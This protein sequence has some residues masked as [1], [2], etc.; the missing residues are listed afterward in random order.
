MMWKAI[1]FFLLG[2]LLTKTNADLCMYL[3]QNVVFIWSI[4]FL[5]VFIFFFKY[6]N[7]RKIIQISSLIF[8]L[9]WGS[10]H[11]AP[12]AKEPI[13]SAMVLKSG[14]GF[15]N[16]IVLDKDSS[17]IYEVISN[18]SEASYGQVR[19]FSNNQSTSL[20]FDNTNLCVFIQDR[21]LRPFSLSFLDRINLSLK[22]KIISNLKKN[23]LSLKH[24]HFI[25]SILYGD[26][27]NLS[28]NIKEHFKSLGIYHLL[29]ISG[30][31]FMLI[32]GCIKAICFCPVK[33]LYIL[34]L[35]S[36]S[37][38]I[39]ISMI[40]NT[41][42]CLGVLFFM[43]FCSISGAT[44]RACIIFLSSILLPYITGR[45][46]L[47]KRVSLCMLIQILIFP[48]GVVS[49]GTLIS[50]L[51][52]LSYVCMTRTEIRQELRASSVWGSLIDNFWI[53]SLKSLVL[54]FK[55]LLLIQIKLSAYGCCVFGMVSPLS[56][57]IN[58]LLVPF[59]PL[60]MLSG[61]YLSLFDFDYGFDFLY[62]RSISQEI[63]TLWF[64]IIDG[65]WKIDLKMKDLGLVFF[66]DQGWYKC[67]VSLTA[68]LGVFSLYLTLSGNKDK[69]L[70][71]K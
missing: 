49:L 54:R 7:K 4:F 33:I 20:L 38:W 22:S 19:C 11:S 26:R 68:L 62:F 34:R 21:N 61:I 23:N 31:H 36:P 15:S 55:Q 13:R 18:S 37:S 53:R 40:I 6:K 60:V 65:L 71:I 27:K 52:Y 8:F 1:L 48:Y 70:K 5:L 10:F 41:L 29:V 35:I 32:A 42:V 25:T 28:F 56:L 50:W 24:I 57:F 2:T 63:I 45:M 64:Y 46:K 66:L 43:S 59:F 44:E 47:E 67:L 58:I 69:R 17:K 39:S 51:C 3:Y 14:L 30:L 12:S 9:L 16:I